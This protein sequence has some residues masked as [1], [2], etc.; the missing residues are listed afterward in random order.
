MSETE[1][2]QGEEQIE[3]PM[4]R[5]TAPSDLVYRA[6]QGEHGTVEGMV[7]PYNEWVEIDSFVEGNFMERFA[8]G[9]LRKTFMEGK[10]RL[11]GY[12]EHGRSRMF[13]RMPIMRI[14]DAWDDDTGGYFRAPLLPSVPPLIREGLEAGVYGASIGARFV[15]VSR[16][17]KPGKSDHNPKGLPE[18]TYNEVRAFDISLTP[19]PAYQSTHAT[20]R[21]VTDD[22]LMEQL[23]S[24][25]QRL[26]DLIVARAEIEVPEV[27]TE[28]P[29][30][31]HEEQEAPVPQWSRGTHPARD[32]LKDERKP[33]W[34]LT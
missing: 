19:S 32:Y 6:D 31:G 28:P 5:S 11:K 34:R 9:S 23:L 2:E 24:D 12:F 7:V 20:L 14:E 18:R 29:H 4:Y 8:P 15:K 27:E 22:L 10:S 1:L 30:S 3:A 13:D 17:R 16:D 25:P 26:R 21:S 33:R